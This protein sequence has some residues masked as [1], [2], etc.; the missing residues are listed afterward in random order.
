MNG[1]LNLGIAYSK[2][3]K[4][5]SAKY[6]W[7]IAKRIY[8]GQPNLPQYYSL[9]GQIFTYT[10]K[11]LAKESKYKQAVHEFETGLQCSPSN[12]DIWFNLGGT[13]FN[14]QQY[15]SAR[16]AW[17][18]VKQINPNYPNLDKYFGMLPKPFQDSNSSPGFK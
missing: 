13:F 6:F 17:L 7:D 2:L 1:Y 3:I 5:D 10:G 11:Q 18:R 12:P 15:D 4:P 16:Y 9:L 8:S 14:M